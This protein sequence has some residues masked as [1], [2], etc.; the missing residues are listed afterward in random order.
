MKNCS[1]IQ[2]YK[3]QLRLRRESR[4]YKKL[5]INT[6]NVTTI[7]ATI[8]SHCHGRNLVAHL[9]LKPTAMSTKFWIGEG[10]RQGRISVQSEGVCSM[11]ALYIL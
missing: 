8:M 10:R 6:T 1:A 9:D 2:G 7:A 11:F 3:F 5:Q 4:Y